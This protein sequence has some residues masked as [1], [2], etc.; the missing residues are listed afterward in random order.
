MYNL[1]LWIKQLIKQYK[2]QG[3]LR[4]GPGSCLSCIGQ[5]ESISVN[6]PIILTILNVSS[7][8]NILI[9]DSFSF[10]LQKPKSLPLYSIIE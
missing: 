7:N 8:C 5:H 2:L 3:A 1:F 10:S 4:K 9:T 6:C